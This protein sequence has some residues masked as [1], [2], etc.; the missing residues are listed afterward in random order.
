MQ[1]EWYGQSAFRLRDGAVTVFIDPWDAALFARHGRR[2]DYPP[3]TGVEPDLLLVT[4]EH[5]DHNHVEAVG[6]DPAVIRSTAGTHASPIGDVV[7]IA[8]EHD[9]VAGTQRGHNT[10]YVFSLGDMRVAHLG[11]LGQ[12]AL[13]QEQLDA[14]GRVD[15]L[16][17]P[18]GGGPTIGAEQARTIVDQVHARYVVPHHYRTK[19]I[20]FLDPLD[21]FGS[22]FTRV[23]EAAGPVVEIDDLPNGGDPLLVVPAAP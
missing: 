16:L 14:L 18:V 19:R 6:G 21:D 22:R 13:R 5:G 9:P 17:I 20:D 8:S 23:H 12:S 11:D 4:H 15:L 3:I 1:L 7:G 10:L 2:W